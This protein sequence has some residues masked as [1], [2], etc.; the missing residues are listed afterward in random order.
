MI[1]TIVLANTPV[2]SHN[3]HLFFVVGT[4]KN[5]SCSTSQVY[6][7]ALLTIVTMLYVRPP[8]LTHPIS[9]IVVH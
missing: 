8:E 4:F 1:T 2:V 9:N 5:Y 6:K 7:T 3:Y